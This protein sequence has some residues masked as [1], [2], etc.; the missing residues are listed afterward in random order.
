[1]PK[2]FPVLLLLAAAPPACEEVEHG[3]TV[4]RHE[5]TIPAGDTASVLVVPPYMLELCDDVTD[6]CTAYES[7]GLVLGVLTVTAPPEG[8]LRVSWWAWEE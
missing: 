2:L 6:R 4:A 5:V 7:P 8:Y 3:Q 1:M